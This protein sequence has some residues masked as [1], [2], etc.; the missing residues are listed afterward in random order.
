M[1]ISD[2]HCR[3][4]VRVRGWV[5]E[6]GVHALSSKASVGCLD[7]HVSSGAWSKALLHILSPTGP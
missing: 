4:E 6:E 1:G 7:L 3:E 2:L 5:W